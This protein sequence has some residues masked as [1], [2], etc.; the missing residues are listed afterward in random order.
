MDWL[1]GVGGWMERRIIDFD[2]SKKRSIAILG[3]KGAGKTTLW[4]SLQDKINT[5]PIE[6]SFDE[7]GKF[8]IK[9][10]GTFTVKLSPAIDIGGGDDYVKNY[11][12]IIKNETQIFFL[13]DIRAFE[14]ESRVILARVYKIIS[15]VSEKEI[16]GVSMQFVGTHFDKYR[17]MNWLFFWRRKKRLNDAKKIVMA[18]LNLEILRKVSN[19]KIKFMP[20]IMIVNLLKKKYVDEIKDCILGGWNA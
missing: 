4:N 6:T 3:M 11:G 7:V 2:S 5:D 19:D 15:L 8:Y 9:K 18:K 1:G 12:D 16:K 13:F 17:K 10:D 20:S 14:K